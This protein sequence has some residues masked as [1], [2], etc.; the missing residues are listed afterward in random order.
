MGCDIHLYAEKKIDEKW[1]CLNPL[2]W[3]VYDRKPYKHRTVE[4]FN[5]ERSYVLFG[6][7][8]NVRTLQE[9][10]FGEAKGFP[11][12]VSKEIKEKYEEWGLDA[13]SASYLTLKELNEKFA[14]TSIKSYFDFFYKDIIENILEYHNIDTLHK[15]END[16]RIV[17][18]FDN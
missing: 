11:K 3:D 10:G 1:V 5:I 15:D 13:H 7:L 6:F 17:F 9:K 18:W 4:Q 12:D 2:M 16:I 14:D 8:A